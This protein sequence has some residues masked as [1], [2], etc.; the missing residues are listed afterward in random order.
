LKTAV[1]DIEVYFHIIKCYNVPELTQ[2]CDKI[3]KNTQ[4]QLTAHCFD[5]VTVRRQV[6]YRLHSAL[7]WYENGSEETT[8]VVVGWN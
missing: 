7:D 8:D 3:Q 4:W 6:F 1:E 5:S 2:I